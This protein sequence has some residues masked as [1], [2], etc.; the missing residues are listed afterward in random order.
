LLVC[1]DYVVVR[2]AIEFLVPPW[3]P[4]LLPLSLVAASARWFSS[5]SSHRADRSM[6]LQTLDSMMFVNLERKINN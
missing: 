2:E 1:I 6:L 4:M 5:S 3:A